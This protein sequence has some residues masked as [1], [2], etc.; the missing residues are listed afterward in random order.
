MEPSEPDEQHAAVL[1]A[2]ANGIG[3]TLSD[4]AAMLVPVGNW[5]VWGWAHHSAPPA[6]QPRLT[7][8]VP[9]GVHVAIGSAAS[10]IDGLVQTHQEA[11]EAR[12]VARLLGHRVGPA[13]FHDD[14]VLLELLTA[15]PI[16]ARRFV[17]AEL[18][19][20]AMADEHMERLRMTLQVY[21]EENLS[22]VRT[23]RRLGVNK[24]T[25][26]YRV[27][28]AEEILGHDVHERRRE[29]EA[30]V[31]LSEIYDALSA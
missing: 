24:N 6:G 8:P 9:A 27:E 12:R 1:E 28:R 14:V 3:S 18:G 31:V 10:G 25:I 17:A 5:L 29:L 20:L 23:A 16:A 19:A 22:P 4:G 26:V 2:V 7:L 15:N 13:V 30:A 21:F 11:V